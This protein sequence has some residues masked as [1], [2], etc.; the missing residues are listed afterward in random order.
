[1]SFPLFVSP[2]SCCFCRSELWDYFSGGAG[3]EISYKEDKSLR[4]P[5]IYASL[6]SLFFLHAS[7]LEGHLS[8]S[9][10]KKIDQVAKWSGLEQRW[11]FFKKVP[12]GWDGWFLVHGELENEQTVDLYRD[13]ETLTIKES[14]RIPPFYSSHKWQTYFYNYLTEPDWPLTPQFLNYL[15]YRWN[16]D[17][18]GDLRLKTIRLMFVDRPKDK[19]YGG[20][21]EEKPLIYRS[22]DCPL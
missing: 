8:T 1:M 5:L 20:D 12:R 13:Q 16:K 11:F 22:Q 6:V 9:L 2:F 15:C 4:G 17:H 7:F 14:K 19:L 18:S 21:F 3:E 10:N